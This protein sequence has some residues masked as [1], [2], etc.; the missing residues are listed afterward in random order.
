[1]SWILAQ[2]QEQ[3]GESS[4][5]NINRYY[6]NPPWP[7]SVSATWDVILIYLRTLYVCCAREKKYLMISPMFSSAY[8]FCYSSRLAALITFVWQ[9]KPVVVSCR[10]LDEGGPPGELVCTRV[11][12]DSGMRSNSERR[13]ALPSAAISE[14]SRLA[15]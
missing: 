11:T 10:L 5:L 7:V 14:M 6:P 13:T 15:S 9:R 3:Y 12:C 8:R 1:M 4:S 2:S